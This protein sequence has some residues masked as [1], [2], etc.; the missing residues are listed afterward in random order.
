MA[1][2]RIV[3]ALEEYR[4]AL[5][6]PIKQATR[7]GHGCNGVVYEVSVCGAPCIA[8][9]IHQIFKEDFISRQDKEAIAERFLRECAILSKLRHPNVVQFIGIW[10]EPSP[11]D[12]SPAAVAGMDCALILEKLFTDLENFIEKYPWSPLPINLHILIDVASGLMYLHS[13]KIV[14]RD[15]N[16]GNVLL[17]NDLRAKV[18]DLGM[19]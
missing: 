13:R 10:N 3:A 11:T 9:L 7:F 19:S 8:K 6:Y 14:H 2:A 12:R 18:A 4:V 17:T 16:A 15:L 1:S 5:D